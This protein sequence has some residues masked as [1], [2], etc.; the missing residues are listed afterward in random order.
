MKFRFRKFISP[1]DYAVCGIPSAIGDTP[2]FSTDL[3][4]NLYNTLTGNGNLIYTWNGAI[5]L[6]AKPTQEKTQDYF[7]REWVEED[8]I[9]VYAPSS[10]KRKAADNEIEMLI[11]AKN[12]KAISSFDIILKTINEYG[13]FEFYDTYNRS[14]RRLVY[15]GIEILENKERSDMRVIHFKIKCTNV[16][17][18]DNYNYN[19]STGGTIN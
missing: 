11:Y 5:L 2:A 3:S 6:S 17:G 1:S 13:I 4:L 19:P 10:R 15:D 16:L 8:G 14:L 9:D 12:K 18:Y 7:K